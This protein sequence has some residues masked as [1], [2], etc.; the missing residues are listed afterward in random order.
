LTQHFADWICH[1]TAYHILA[2]INM[3]VQFNNFNWVSFYALTISFCCTH[4]YFS[5]IIEKKHNILGKTRMWYIHRTYN[6]MWLHELQLRDTVPGCNYCTVSSQL[7]IM[8]SHRISYATRVSYPGL[9]TPFLVLTILSITYTK[10]AYHTDISHF[11][12]CIFHK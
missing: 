1:R 5:L 7:P 2:I 8:Q 11:S 6:S 12:K 3:C 9:A 10:V 4:L